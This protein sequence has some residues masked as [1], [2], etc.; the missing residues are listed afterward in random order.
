MH[1]AVAVAR[2]VTVGGL[3]VLGEHKV[4]G[5]GRVEP[6]I[7]GRVKLAK[8]DDAAALRSDARGNKCVALGGDVVAR[9]DKRQARAAEGEDRGVVA[10]RGGRDLED[11]GRARELLELRKELEELPGLDCEEDRE[12]NGGRGGGG[13][14]GAGQLRRGDEGCAVERHSRV[15]L[16]VD[17]HLVQ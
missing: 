6:K 8:V 11:D 16:A 13:E 5:D 1:L 15:G 14:G 12:G 10:G 2:A 17:A 3:C 7:D 4:G 9:V